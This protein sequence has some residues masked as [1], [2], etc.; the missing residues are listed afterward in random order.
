MDYV[1]VSARFRPLLGSNEIKSGSAPW[2]WDTSQVYLSDPATGEK[3]LQLDH[4]FPPDSENDQVYHQV[5]LPVVNHVLNGYNGTI[6]CYGQTGSGKTHTII[7][8]DKQV[9]ILE[10]CVRDL[11][12]DISR[13]PDYTAK[14]S[15]LEIY[16]EN[17]YDL[18]QPGGNILK[19]LRDDSVFGVI[20]ENL[21]EIPVASADTV[22]NIIQSGEEVRH[23]R[24]TNMNERSS[25]SH[26]LFRFMIE[27][28][29]DNGDKTVSCISIVDLAGSE[30]QSKSNTCG[31]A[32]KEGGNI[33]RSLLALQ[34][35]IAS[36]ADSKDFIQYRNSKLTRLLRQ[37]LG[38]NSMTCLICTVTPGNKNKQESMNTL[39]FGTTCKRIKNHATKNQFLSSD[40]LL[41]KYKEDLAHLQHELQRQKEKNYTISHEIQVNTEEK[42]ETNDV[43]R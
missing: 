31:L 7:G 39:L 26:T 11:F 15:Y 27:R 24:S 32:L 19:I 38:G 40:S 12:K 25:R 36:L 23:Y 30:R 5:A 3:F 2:K 1:K 4:V 35:V 14:V 42:T 10:S 17:I 13:Q 9:G 18:L 22:M 28:L 8:S 43:T 34:E 29:N 16:N 6:L 33:N 41:A 21:T 37:S 20:L